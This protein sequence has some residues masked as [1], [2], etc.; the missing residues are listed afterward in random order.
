MHHRPVNTTK[1]A[2]LCTGI[3]TPVVSP[4]SYLNWKGKEPGNLHAN[5]TDDVLSSIWLQQSCQDLEWVQKGVTFIEVITAPITAAGEKWLIHIVTG[6]KNACWCW[7]SI[8]VWLHE[9]VPVWWVVQWMAVIREWE[10]W[11]LASSTVGDSYNTENDTAN[12]WWVHGTVGD[13]YNSDNENADVW[14][15]VQ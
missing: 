6:D 3:S 4:L 9:T 2:Q 7:P 8:S 10:C 1:N 11:C 5:I 15:V 13:S 12:I 14:W